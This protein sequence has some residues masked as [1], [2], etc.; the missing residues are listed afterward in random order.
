MKNK[1]AVSAVILVFCNVNAF[2]MTYS[3]QQDLGVKGLMRYCKY[4]NGQVYTFESTDLCEVTI[5]DTAPG[6]GKGTGFLAGEYEEGMTKICVYDVLGEKRLIRQNGV[7][8]CPVSF[9]FDN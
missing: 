9:R 1:I 6:M 5:E 8:I 4:S 3:L 7:S 2:A